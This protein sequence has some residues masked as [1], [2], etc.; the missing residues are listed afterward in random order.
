[1]DIEIDM[2]VI[3]PDP[4]ET[5]LHLHSFAGRVI[6]FRAGYAQVEDQD[7]NIFEIEPE[8]LTLDV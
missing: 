1:M 6:G 3:V 8:R 7:G 2:N 4:D 5:D